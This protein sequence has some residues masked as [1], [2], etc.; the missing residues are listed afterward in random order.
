MTRAATIRRLRDRLSAKRIAIESDDK[1]VRATVD[2]LGSL[3]QL[4]ISENA[5]TRQNASR[6]GR[7]ILLTIRRAEL[8]VE[9]LHRQLVESLPHDED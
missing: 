6:L 2:G 7:D 5:I 9:S 8:T 1:L 3:L 4:E